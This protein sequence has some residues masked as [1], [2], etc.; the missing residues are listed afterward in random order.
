M[1]SLIPRI[2]G[3]AKSLCDPIPESE[4]KEHERREVL[5]R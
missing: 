5:R 1:E 4:V 3:L 2:E